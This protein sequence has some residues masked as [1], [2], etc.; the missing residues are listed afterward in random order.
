MVLERES[1]RSLSTTTNHNTTKGGGKES[2]IIN[3]NQT[4]TE[5]ERGKKK[6]VLLHKKKENLRRKRVFGVEGRFYLSGQPETNELS[7]QSF[8]TQIPTNRDPEA[9]RPHVVREKTLGEQRG[10]INLS[11]LQR[12]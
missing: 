5:G 2:W 12:R 9:R 3:N 1:G 11:N 6:E 7:S 10:K 8:H 4:V